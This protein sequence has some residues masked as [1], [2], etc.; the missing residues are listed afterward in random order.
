MVVA[1]RVLA[2]AVLMALLSTQIG[3]A[4]NAQAPY[5][6]NVILPITG[7]AAFLGTKEAE[8][9]GVIEKQVNRTGGIRGRS[10]HFVV[11]DDASDPKTD[12][13]I[14]SGLV[15][16]HV[17]VVIGSSVSSM[18]AAMAPLVKDNGPVLY[19][20]SPLVE[21][22]S[23]SFVFSAAIGSVAFMPLLPEYAHLKHWKRVALL[24]TNDTTGQDY[25]TKMDAELKQPGNSDVT[26]VASE[27]FAASDLSV[28]AQVANIKAA[29]PDVAVVV[30]TGP[31]FGLSLRAFKDAGLDIPLIVT[32]SNI[33]NT[34]MTQF[35]SVLPSKMYF[36]SAAGAK[37]DPS[38]R[39]A[40]KAAQSTFFDAFKSAGIIPEYS[41]LLAWDPTMLVVDALRKTGLTASA[42]QIRAEIAGRREWYGLE[43]RYDFGASPQRG[44]SRKN[45]V[46]YEWVTAKNDYT[47][48]FADK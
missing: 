30:A 20:L 35:H 44:L 22:P 4:Q 13:Q 46:V 29:R 24:A 26:V 5:D 21:P 18:C 34:Q 10:I 32:G 36:I 25:E 16:R 9:I 15:Q 37:A 48:V 28:A 2:P 1:L 14:I 42:E 17:P 19:C 43:G 40:W 27:H 41:H 7:G 45:A 47:V 8:A 6:V 38:A 31:P 3:S 12:V 39:G 11:S 33:T 23:G